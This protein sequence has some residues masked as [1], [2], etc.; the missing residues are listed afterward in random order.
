MSAAVVLRGKATLEG[1]VGSFDCFVANVSNLNPSVKVTQQYEPEILK[2]NHGYDAVWLARNEHAIVDCEL[3]LCA[4]THAIAIA[5]MQ[6]PTS[7]VN[8]SGVSALGQPF[9]KPWACM[10]LSNFELTAFNGIFQIL[11][12]GEATLTQSGAAKYTLKLLKYADTAGQGAAILV[13]PT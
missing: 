13:V 2:D 12:G 10:T 11:S 9:L 6:S 8:S 4:T 7:D 5:P 3:Y 1:T